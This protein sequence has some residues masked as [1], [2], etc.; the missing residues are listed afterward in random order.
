MGSDLDS[1][2]LAYRKEQVIELLWGSVLQLPTGDNHVCPVS[3]KALWV[4]QCDTNKIT[5]L[6]TVYRRHLIGNT[7]DCMEGICRDVEAMLLIQC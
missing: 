7:T 6:S 1:A 5:A 4:M 3:M 2:A